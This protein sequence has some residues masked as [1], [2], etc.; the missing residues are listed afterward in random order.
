MYNAAS[1]GAVFSEE[2]C[3]GL[4]DAAQAMRECMGRECDKGTQIE[5]GGWKGKC[6]EYQLHLD[7][8]YDDKEGADLC[9]GW[10]DMECQ[11]I[12]EV[13]LPIP[14]A[15][16]VLAIMEGMGLELR[17]VFCVV[18]A[19]V[20]CVLPQS[21]MWQRLNKIDKEDVEGNVCKNLAGAPVPIVPSA[22][23]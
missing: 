15:G 13:C 6:N 16:A 14:Y 5:G 11:G 8:L 2:N 10:C 4:C 17:V 9:T 19:L 3:R 20:G 18:W 7:D 12:P 22:G 1:T 23:V 21:T